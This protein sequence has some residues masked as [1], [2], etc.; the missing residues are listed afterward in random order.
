MYLFESMII[1]TKP[2]IIRYLIFFMIFAGYNYLIADEDNEERECYVIELTDEYIREFT[3]QRDFFKKAGDRSLKDAQE[4]TAYISV[5]EERTMVEIAINSLIVT[6]GNADNRARLVGLCLVCVHECLKW[7]YESSKECRHYLKY[8]EFCYEMAEFYDSILQ[9]REVTTCE[10]HDEHHR[11]F[12][13]D[14]MPDKRPQQNW[15]FK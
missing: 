6:I 7:A 3:R 11:H 10:E 12:I 8:A 13:E 15:K 5:P 4:K 1:K 2:S 14:D 9:G